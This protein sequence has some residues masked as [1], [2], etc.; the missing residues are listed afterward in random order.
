MGGPSQ[1]N[2]NPEARSKLKLDTDAIMVSIRQLFRAVDAASWYSSEPSLGPL[3]AT[4]GL[5]AVQ[6]RV[7]ECAWVAVLGS[8]QEKQEYG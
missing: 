4:R 5:G 1:V 6:D 8:F 2:W 7:M 3:V